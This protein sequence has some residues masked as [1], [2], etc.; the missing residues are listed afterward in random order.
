MLWISLSAPTL[1]TLSSACAVGTSTARTT[2]AMAATIRFMGPPLSGVPVRKAYAMPFPGRGRAT[3]HS[4]GA[5]CAL[6]VQK[7][8]H[9]AGQ[10]SVGRSE[11]LEDGEVVV[12]A[13]RP[14]LRAARGLCVV[15]RLP[16]QLRQLT[17]A[18]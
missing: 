9:H 11:L 10:F 6:C 17:G 8:A 16:L 12:T 7:G 14:Q 4:L 3:A 18:V 5:I 1:M 2:A 13:E 15:H